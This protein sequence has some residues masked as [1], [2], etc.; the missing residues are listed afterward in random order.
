MRDVQT[1]QMLRQHRMKLFSNEYTD[2]EDAFVL[3]SCRQTEIWESEDKNMLIL[4]Q[5]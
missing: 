2:C 3:L 4:Y 5:D 1:A